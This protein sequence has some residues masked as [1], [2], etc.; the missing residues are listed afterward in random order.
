MNVLNHKP[1]R[2]TSLGFDPKLYPEGVH[3]CFIFDDE[4]D[5]R[6]VLAEYV[7]SGLACGEQV[8]YFVDTMSPAE[9]KH[10][11]CELGVAIPEGE[12]DRECLIVTAE[13]A[14]CPDGTFRAERMLA[15]LE[16]AYLR[17]CDY[18]YAGLRVSGEM[19]WALRK[20]P[21]REVLIDYESRVNRVLRKVPV[22]A[23]CQY[24]ARLFDGETLYRLL[25][26]HPLMI[27]RG[28]VV[29]NPYYS[30]AREH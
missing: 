2:L 9:L 26:V 27:V 8:A 28:M 24:D 6:R 16:Q 23:I 5:R 11:L 21:D 12:A 10:N 29:Q 13:A 7:R 1:A 3:M 25:R 22:T 18:G 15:S 30:E 14:Y 17:S 19:N 20:L 4:D